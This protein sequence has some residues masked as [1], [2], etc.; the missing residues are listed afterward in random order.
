MQTKLK[1]YLRAVFIF[2]NH[3]L[4]TYA[5]TLDFERSSD[6]LSDSQGRYSQDSYTAEE[7]AG[8]YRGARCRFN[9][10]HPGYH[11]FTSYRGL[12]CE[13]IHTVVRQMPKRGSR[14]AFESSP[15]VGLLSA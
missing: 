14:Y 3:A 11:S 5:V 13:A 12:R 15:R 1:I 2:L 6:N 8:I 9:I 10:P 4:Q 7:M